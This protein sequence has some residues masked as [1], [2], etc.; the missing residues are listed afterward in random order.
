M[1]NENEKPEV[2]WDSYIYIRQNRPQIKT[3][4]KDKDRHT[5]R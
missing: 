2:R 4:I 5:Q 1:F 3:V